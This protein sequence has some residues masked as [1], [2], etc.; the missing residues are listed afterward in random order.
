MK[1]YLL[2]LAVIGLALTAC[3]SDASDA[4]QEEEAGAE[5]LAAQPGAG[6]PAANYKFPDI[7]GKE[8]QLSQFDYED[9]NIR[10]VQGSMVTMLIV[11]DKVSGNAGCND[12]QATAAIQAGGKISF[13]NVEKLSKNI[14][15]Q[16]MTQ[17]TWVLELIQTAQ[18]YDAQLALLEVSSPKGKLTF[19][20]VGN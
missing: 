6:A 12:Y 11:G 14:C 20:Y 3:K 5:A 10:P 17:E 7:E 16:R 8:W 15:T 18:S 4:Q 1:Y 9:K 19:R 2:A 13:A